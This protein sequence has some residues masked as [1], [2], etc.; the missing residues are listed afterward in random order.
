MNHGPNTQNDNG[1]LMVIGAVAVMLGLIWLTAHTQ[2]AWL[3][4]NVRL[5]EARLL[6]FDH[7]GQRIV[8]HW[9]ATRNPRDVG[10]GELYRSGQVTGYYLR[11]IV[12]ALLL[13]LFVWLFLRH[14]GRSIA[15]RQVHQIMTLARRQAHLYPMIRPMLEMDLLNVPL[16][17]PIHGMR[18]LPRVYARRYG[19]LLAHSQIPPEHPREDLDVIDAKQ[20]LLL[21][22]CREVFSK[23]I[24]KEWTG[25]G[26]LPAYE[27]AL[28]VA[29]AVQASETIEKGNDK[30][31]KIIEEL[32]N[33]ATLAFRKGDVTLIGSV[34]ADALEAEALAAKPVQKILRRHGWRRTMLMG[35]LEQARQ[36]GVLPAAWFR[37]LKPV[38]RVTWYC[39]CDLGMHPSSVE[40]AGVRAQFQIEKA[41]KGPVLTPMI[42]SAVNGLRDY[43]NEVIEETDDD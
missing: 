25:V 9:V 29:F 35:M 12:L 39:L 26:A 32:A 7:V 43:L 24:G 34:T 42:E 19:M 8:Y 6:S 33:T 23:Q 27:K 36:G 41:A 14:P 17:H 4:M 21:G 5:L 28:L 40:S 38:D 20:V 15:F 13:P 11:W 3:V 16:D 2:I 10:F 37:W 18:A 31:L 1:P 22:R 30:A